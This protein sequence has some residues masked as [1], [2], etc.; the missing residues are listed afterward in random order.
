MAVISAMIAVVLI[1]FGFVD[2]VSIVR[3]IFRGRTVGSDGVE[4]T[5]SHRRRMLIHV[6][7]TC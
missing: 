1:I 2:M 4:P 5:N 6:G 3:E 7:D